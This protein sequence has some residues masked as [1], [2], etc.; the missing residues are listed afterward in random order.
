MVLSLVE[1]KGGIAEIPV[2]PDDVLREVGMLVASLSKSKAVNFIISSAMF[3]TSASVITWS[4]AVLQPASPISGPWTA[5]LHCTVCPWLLL[6]CWQ[7]LCLHTSW[8][9]LNLVENFVDFSIDFSYL[10]KFFCWLL[11]SITVIS[12]LWKIITTIWHLGK[13]CNS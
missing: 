12:F 9:C 3:L 6:Q 13:F 11:S 1:S 4:V 10:F 8:K 5:A 2:A 7:G